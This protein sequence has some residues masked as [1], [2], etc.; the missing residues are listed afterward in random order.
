MEMLLIREELWSV[1]DAAKPN[2]VTD[3]WKKI[4]TK[5]RATIGLCVDD[6]Q[7]SLIRN[8][9]SAKDVWD[10]LKNYHDKGSEVYLLKK[11]T[12]LELPEGGDMEQHL[13]EFTDLLQRIADA[14]EG[15][16]AKWQVAIL[17]CSLPESYDP[18]TT[19]LEQRPIAELTLDLVKSKLLAEAEKR[20]ERTGSA[21]GSGEKALRTDFN[22]SR[23]S[24]SVL[25]RIVAWKRVSVTIAKSRDISD[26]IV[27]Y[28]KSSRTTTTTTTKEPLKPSKQR[29]KTF[30]YAL[31]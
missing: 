26:E 8:C 7:T 23:G 9:T 13:Q 31:Q 2:P 28:S 11:L 3:A 17:L 1:I 18:L 25:V 22:K 6:S 20:R 30:R 15:I 19:A 10:A 29:R 27:D 16:P 5:A 4:D 21:T 12:R 24:V 14:G